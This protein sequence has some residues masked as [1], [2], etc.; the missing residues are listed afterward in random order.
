MKIVAP[1]F[2]STAGMRAQPSLRVLTVS[3]AR[4]MFTTEI[5]AGILASVRQSAACIKV[6][7]RSR[8][9]SKAFTAWQVDAL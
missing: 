7:R 5:V 9:K 3:G 8:Q 4:C 6:G 1:L 2:V